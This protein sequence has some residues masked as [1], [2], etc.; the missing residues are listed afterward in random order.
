MYPPWPRASVRP[1]TLPPLP[2]PTKARYVALIAL[3]LIDAEL[4]ERDG[5]WPT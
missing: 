1:V 5:W 3:E 4:Y 2:V